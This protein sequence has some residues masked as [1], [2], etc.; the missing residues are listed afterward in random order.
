MFDWNEFKIL[1]EKLKDE[2][3]EASQR[4]AIS[5]L[6]YAIYW[7]ARIQIE[8]KGYVYDRYQSSHK[9]IWNAYLS[10]S[11][12]N[13]KDI[14]KKGD[15]LHKKR[16]KADYLDEIRKLNNLVED[17]FLVANEIIEALKKV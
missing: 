10:K 1:A 14:G 9:Q 15:E 11:D 6:Y 8:S 3:H 7:K 17:S 12:P 16:I 4:T 2:K 5:R 13:N